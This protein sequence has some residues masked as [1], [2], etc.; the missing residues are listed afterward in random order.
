MGKVT[1]FLEEK[2]AKQPYRPVDERLDDYHQ[3]ISRSGKAKLVCH[4]KQE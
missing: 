1:G 3:V 4:Y 2:R